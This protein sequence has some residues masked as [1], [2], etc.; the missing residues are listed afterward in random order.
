M[1]SKNEK[2]SSEKVHE[3]MEL[4][5]EASHD[6][7]VELRELMGDTLQKAKAAKDQAIDRAKEKAS[8]VDETVHKNP[9]PFVGG[10]ALGGFFLGLLLRLRNKK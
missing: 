2:K 7:Q 1:S 8:Q 4:L 5:K 10:A 3:A 6:K 9:W